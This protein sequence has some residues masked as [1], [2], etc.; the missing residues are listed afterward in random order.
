MAMALE[1]IQQR[2]PKQENGKGEFSAG[3]LVNLKNSLVSFHIH[4][5]EEYMDVA[6]RQKENT[7]GKNRSLY[8]E[9]QLEVGK[10]LIS[11]FVK[12]ARLNNHLAV[13]AS[14]LDIHSNQEQIII[15]NDVHKSNLLMF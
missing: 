14:K 5:R 10:A 3:Y 4:K 1:A 2:Q 15:Q 11:H 12:K 8:T 9:E 13:E 7:L 6:R